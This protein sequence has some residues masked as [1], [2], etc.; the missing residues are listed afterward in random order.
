MAILYITEFELIPLAPNGETLWLANMSQIV[1]QQTVTYTTTTPSAT[2]FNS[3]TSFVRLYSDEKAHLNFGSTPIATVE[4]AP[5]AA[6]SPEY[7]GVNPG[8]KVAAYDGTS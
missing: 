2:A 7:F 8:D 1:A 5:I 4:D 6:D 3:R